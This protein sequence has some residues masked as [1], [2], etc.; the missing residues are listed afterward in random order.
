M[1]GRYLLTASRDGL[2]NWFGF[3]DGPAIQARYNIAP[4]H[5]IPVVRLTSEG[6]EREPSLLRWGLIPSWA[7]DVSFGF[8]TINARSETIADK[9]AFR[10]AFRRQRCLIPADG[11]YEWKK[12]GKNKQPYVI[13]PA[14]GHALAYAGLWERW[15]STEGEVLES[16][17]I[18]TTPANEVLR[19]LHERMPTILPREHYTLWL[20]AKLQ[21]GDLFHLLIP[22]PTT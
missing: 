20:D 11:F 19:P 4:S 15:H 17:T 12:A 14:D 9:P 22:I 3:T 16:T 5:S 6:K 2:A 7:K 18:I 1:C 13:R 8:K 10:S 21:K